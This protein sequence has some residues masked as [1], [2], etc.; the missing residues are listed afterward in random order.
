[1]RTTLTFSIL[2]I[3]YSPGPAV[4]ELP[5]VGGEGRTWTGGSAGLIRTGLKVPVSLKT[6]G[7]KVSPTDPWYDE[8]GEPKSGACGG[9]NLDDSTL[10]AGDSS[11]VTDPS[12]GYAC[13]QWYAPD[14][15]GVAEGPSAWKYRGEYEE[16]GRNWVWAGAMMFASAPQWTQRKSLV[17]SGSSR[18]V[19]STTPK[20]SRQTRDLHGPSAQ[21]TASQHPSTSH[22]LT[23]SLASTESKGKNDAG[24]KSARRCSRGGSGESAME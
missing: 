1:M 2:T 22:V 24:R 16:S 7:L 14:S 18:A 17:P 23:A 15:V 12:P 19:L 11:T 10:S 8:G 4:I 13:S 20:C 21:K 6:I 3:G 5:D 9:G